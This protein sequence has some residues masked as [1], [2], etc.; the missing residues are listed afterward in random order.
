[1]CLDFCKKIGLFTNYIKLQM[2]ASFHR[3]LFKQDGSRATW[4][5]PFA[6]AGINVIFYVDSDVGF[7]FRF[8]GNVNYLSLK[9]SL[10]FL[11]K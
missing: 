11:K 9:C 10:I 3:L 5:Y 6:V 7:V 2:K 1:M 4:E 8:V